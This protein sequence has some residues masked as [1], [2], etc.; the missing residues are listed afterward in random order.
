MVQYPGINQSSFDPELREK[1]SQKATYSVSI[2]NRI[3][4]EQL[5]KG[6]EKMSCRLQLNSWF[7]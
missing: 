6:K 5:N 3:I 2:F 7:Y 1:L 4:L